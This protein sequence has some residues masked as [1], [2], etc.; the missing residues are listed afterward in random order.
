MS[1]TPYPS[2]AVVGESCC[3]SA[4]SWP[5]IIAG[6]FAAAAVSLA[7]LLLGSSLGLAT[8]SPWSRGDFSPVAL[9]A[10][11]AS[12]LVVMQWFSAGLGAYIT[13]RLRTRWNNTD[14]DEVFFRDTAHGFLTWAVATIFTAAFLA[15]AASAVIGGSHDMMKHH[16]RGPG[17]A[18]FGMNYY[19]DTLLRTSKNV[20]RAARNEVK[21]ILL[22]DMMRDGK[23]G[24]DKA[25]LSQVVAM[26]TGLSDSEA[27]Q[28]VD[29]V[30][31][32]MEADKVEA[33]KAA[34]T[35]RKT[36]ATTAI[37][38]F[39]SMLVGAFVACV[40]AAIGGKNRDEV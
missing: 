25:Q 12:W 36:A 33:K 1:P 9:T 14:R 37:F 6:A 30:M 28:R 19:A 38:T 22:H 17:P 39:L 5:A 11:T 27:R 20:D 32:Q 24:E 3:G 35:A 15:S 23:I 2:S 4:V 40:A 10:K 8:A 13:G 16:M 34:D 26:H 7:L 18:M 21:G 31:T 29:N